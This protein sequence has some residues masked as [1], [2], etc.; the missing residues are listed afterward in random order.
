MTLVVS[1]SPREEGIDFKPAQGMLGS[2]T[3]VWIGENRFEGIRKYQWGPIG[4]EDHE[5]PGWVTLILKPEEAKL[6]NE[7]NF[8]FYETYLRFFL[9]N[10][11]FIE[12]E[13]APP[14]AN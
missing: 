1:F 8:V 5:L 14:Q 2:V 9:D 13:P 4:L 11:T 3:G 7:R 10:A 6:K 12:V